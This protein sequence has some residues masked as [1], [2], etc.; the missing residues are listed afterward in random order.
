MRNLALVC[1]G[2][3]IVSSIISVNLWRELRAERLVA[4]ELRAQ[5]LEQQGPAMPQTGLSAAAVATPATITET[6]AAP[7]RPLAATPSPQATPARNVAT[8]VLVEARDLLKDPEYRRAALAQRRL[9]MPQ[10][11]PDLAEE[12]NLTP[13]Q[14]DQLYDLLAAAQITQQAELVLPGSQPGQPIDLSVM[15]NYTRRSQE[16]QA[17]RDEQIAALL[18][19]AGLDQFKAYEQTVPARMQAQNIQRMMETGGM[20]LTAAQMK[21]ITAA[22]IADQQRQRDMM[23]TMF[24]QTTAG[25]NPEAAAARLQELQSERQVERNRSLIEAARPHLTAQQLERLQ[26]T[27]DQQ[28]A[29]SRASSRLMRERIEAQAGATGTVQGITV[30]QAAPALPAP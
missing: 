11:Y 1:G 16:L 20:P 13:E 2:L 22:Y 3:A 9:N 6:A 25:A 8:N 29:M 30:I 15:E 18:G 12:L 14:T 19:N 24:T 23:T 17:R 7:P 28:L 5:L 27:L 10:N 4:G 26:A 21:P